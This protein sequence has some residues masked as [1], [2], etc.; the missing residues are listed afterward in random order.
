[1]KPGKLGREDASG[2]QATGSRKQG[3]VIRRA[4]EEP[5]F[6]LFDIFLTMLKFLGEATGTFHA[7]G[8]T[9]FGLSEFPAT[10]N[11]SLVSSCRVTTYYQGPNERDSDERREKGNQKWK[12][13]NTVIHLRDSSCRD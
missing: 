2:S 13:G 3:D 1:L 10:R 11:E 5:L 9:L 7:P 8:Y 6:L 4:D 12:K